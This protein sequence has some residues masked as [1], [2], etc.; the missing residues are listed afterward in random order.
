MKI[1]MKMT[2]LDPNKIKTPSNLV[3]NEDFKQRFQEDKDFR[4][5]KRINH[6]DNRKHG[7]WEEL[8]ESKIRQIIG[9]GVVT[10]GSE[11]FKYGKSR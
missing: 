6:K 4:G 11:R 1:R 5:Q 8:L 7:G 3:N 10:K 9:Y 2:T